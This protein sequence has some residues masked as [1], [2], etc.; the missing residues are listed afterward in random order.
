MISGVW[1]FTISSLQIEY[2]QILTGDFSLL[3]GN[4]I[5]VLVTSVGN[6]PSSILSLTVALRFRLLKQSSA[7]LHAVS[8]ER[9]SALRTTRMKYQPIHAYKLCSKSAFFVAHMKP[10][11][12]HMIS[13]EVTSDIRITNTDR[14]AHYDTH[15]KTQD[16]KTNHDEQHLTE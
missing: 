11:T 10:I 16:E 3:S 6:S 9:K 2:Q 5:V 12:L 7:F 8:F 15:N 13:N 4:T 1:M 14:V